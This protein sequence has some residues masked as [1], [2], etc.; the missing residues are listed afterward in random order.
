MEFNIAQD[1][2]NWYIYHT[3]MV[4]LKDRVSNENLSKK[5]KLNF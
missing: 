2:I 1:L 3:Q 4:K 5:I